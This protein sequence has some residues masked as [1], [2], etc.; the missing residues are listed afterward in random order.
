[1]V[2]KSW[3]IDAERILVVSPHL[4]DAVLGC[5]DV[6]GARPGAVVVTVF[7]GSPPPGPA[8]TDWDAASGFGPGEDA[9]ARRRDEDRAALALLSARPVWLPFLDAQYEAPAGPGEIAERLAKAIADATPD[10]VLIPAGLWHVDH[11]LTHEAAVDAMPRC[12]PVPWLAYEDAIYRAFPEP[13]LDARRR[14]L[15]ERG[16]DAVPLAP[17]PPAS[18]LKRR[19]IETYR[20]QTRALDGPLG[21]G[22]GDALEPERYWQLR[23]IAAPTAATPPRVP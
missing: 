22:W 1:M 7:A 20:S 3:P 21:P 17:G 16:I 11:R 6:I 15:R 4:D 13:G 19:S 23:P 10:A 12:R 18:P 8:P 9:V 2:A 14:W 5:A